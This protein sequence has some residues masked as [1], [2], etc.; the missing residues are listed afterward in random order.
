MLTSE[1]FQN[2]LLDYLYDLLDEADA[3]AMR[4]YLESHPEAPAQAERT[5]QLLAAAARK[6]FPN[7]QF[8]P[9]GSEA[10]AHA[11]GSAEALARAPGSKR[12][13]RR[14]LLSWAVAASVL[15]VLGV[16]SIP[17]GR[18]IH[19]YVNAR[20]R[21][22]QAQGKKDAAETSLKVA[23][24]DHNRAIE[25]AREKVEKVKSEIAALEEDRAKDL[26]KV[27]EDWKNKSISLEVTGPK[28]LVAG[29]PNDFTVRTKDRDGKDAHS[30][31][32][33]RLMNGAETLFEQTVSESQGLCAIHLPPSVPIRP[34]S[35]LA[36]QVQ[37][38]DKAGELQSEVTETLQWAAPRYSTHLATDKPLYQIDKHETVFFRSLTLNRATMTPPDE[39][40]HV[41]FS[42]KNPKG[43]VIWKKGGATRLSYPAN[44]GVAK[45]L[46]GPDRKPVHGIA[47]GEFAIPDTLEDGG[48]YILTVHELNGRFPDEQRKFLINKYTPDRLLKELEWD[49]K[50]YGPGAEVVATCK[51]KAGNEP[52]A[53][54]KVVAAQVVVDST[55]FDIPQNSLGQTDA[56]G[57]VKVKFKLPEK[58]DK[59]N[60]SLTVIF[61]DGGAQESIQKPIPI[62]LNKLFFEYYPE[63]GYL[64]AGVPNRVY[65]QVRNTRDKPAEMKGR[66]VDSKGQ[67]AASTETLH[68]DNEPGANQGM[69][70]FRFT[71][72][73]GETYKLVLEEPVGAEA[74]G[75]WPEVQA[76]GVAMF[77]PSGVT[78]GGEPI[79]VELFDTKSRQLLVGAYCRGR[80]LDH[81]RVLTEA[82]KTVAVELKPESDL[83]GV[84]RITVFEEEAGPGSRK[85]LTPRAERLVFRRSARKLDF[86]IQADKNR[87]SPGGPVKLTIHAT[88]EKGL[89]APA[90]IMIAATNE[91]VLK[92]AD[93][94]TERSMPTDFA[95]KSEVRRAEELEHADFLMNEQN[96][97]APVALDLLLGVQGWRRFA[98]QKKPG[99]VPEMNA[100]VAERLA[101]LTGQAS[102]QSIDTRVQREQEVEQ[103]VFQ[104]KKEL[105]DELKAAVAAR[106]EVLEDPTF[107]Q[108]EQ[109]HRLEVRQSWKDYASAQAALEPYEATNGELRRFGLPVLAFGCLL[110][111]VALVA[112]AAVRQ[113]RKAIP[114]YATA[115]AS[116]VGCIVVVVILYSSPES[117]S[118][119]VVVDPTRTYGAQ[120]TGDGAALRELQRPVG[121]DDKAAFARPEKDEGMDRWGG[122]WPMPA[123]PPA[124]GGAGFGQGGVAGR[125]NVPPMAGGGAVPGTGMQAKAA[126]MPRQARG[127]AMPPPGAPKPTEAPAAAALAMAPALRNP[128]GDDKKEG[129]QDLA[130]GAN[131]AKGA[132]AN[133]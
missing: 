40:F 48:E 105:S 61:F 70:S 106:A 33:F 18:H 65:Y 79:R 69:G 133:F 54:R 38:K 28:Q 113:V 85:N 103:K 116:I 112:V 92:M 35:Q 47:A 21:M 34:N 37:A 9:P 55:A 121:L 10:V 29:A 7:V 130:R 86:Q 44:D 99:Q 80:L 67:T 98:E 32:I 25:E 68:E 64:V 107:P 56:N 114:Y 93:E 126:D 13:M 17:A 111:A 52:L 58:M 50:S 84:V 127:G 12:P 53:H 24:A 74:V 8:V 26:E 20:D 94:K 19:G 87:Y 102:R 5:R 97:K 27:K 104:Q 46:L 51:V 71:P 129:K 22:I 16:L 63:G 72:K 6:E 81:Q 96:P 120:A 43:A 2:Q 95:I 66:I 45:Q 115:A 108:T 100:E 15:L 3:K 76:E 123:T 39:D 75:K 109:T 23:I 57:C 83:G 119:K 14:I 131:G 1:Q 4:E 91:S 101:I 117:Q 30:G 128:A 118:G 89:P 125:P 11:S 62:S 82:G 77:V 42:I 31:I 41:E 132:V 88:D 90:V 59:G 78:A 73:A 110:L 49:R 124:P 122:N 36:I 60:G